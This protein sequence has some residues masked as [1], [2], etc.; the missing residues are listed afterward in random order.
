[1]PKPDVVGCQTGSRPYLLGRHFETHDVVLY[2]PDCKLWKCQY[3]SNV[4]AKQWA[5]RA[6]KGIRELDDR[7]WYFLTTTVKESTG[8]LK[9]QIN[10]M[11]N[12][13]DKLLK[14]GKRIFPGD[15]HTFTVP[16]RGE[17]NG[18]LHYHT[19]VDCAWGCY[20]N[21]ACLRSQWLHDNLVEIGLGYRYDIS[22]LNSIEGVVSYITGYITSGFNVE[23]PRGF[24]RVRVSQNF[25][26]GV[27]EETNTE[28]LWEIIPANSSG[29]RQLLGMYLAG[30]IV[31][32]LE[33]KKPLT[34]SHPFLAR[35]A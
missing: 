34:L 10:I 8:D 17:K 24:R 6:R 33:T 1:M 30:E 16:E 18:R 22:K 28:Y 5:A 2:R 7:D 13:W 14:R 35:M 29:R 20:H 12:G 19:L 4:K 15:W 27:Q 23:F 25:P 32:D 21:G 3:C 9:R 31:K 26:K 11:A